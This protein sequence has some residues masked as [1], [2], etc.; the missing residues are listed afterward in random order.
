MVPI[1]RFGE[2][3]KQA[4]VFNN[5]DYVVFPS[6]FFLSDN[7][8]LVHLSFGY[9]DKFGYMSTFE[10]GPLL[11]SLGQHA[12]CAAPGNKRITSNVTC[13]L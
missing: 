8:T 4:W 5:I 3:Y 12:D 2:L 10:L 9:Q 7:E 6:G 13:S 1:M 11:D